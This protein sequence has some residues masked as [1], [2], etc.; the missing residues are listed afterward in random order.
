V[1]PAI[2]KKAPWPFIFFLSFF[3]QQIEDRASIRIKFCNILVPLTHGKP[4][5]TA[6]HHAERSGTPL[7]PAN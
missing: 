7:L 1:C 5:Y 3:S 4:P 2:E 6:I